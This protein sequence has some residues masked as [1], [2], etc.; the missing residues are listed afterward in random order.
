MGRKIHLQPTGFV[1]FKFPSRIPGMWTPT[2]GRGNLVGM[3]FP[4]R[5]HRR[6]S[7]FYF[8]D[9][10]MIKRERFVSHK[11][12]GHRPPGRFLRFLLGS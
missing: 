1:S 4:P 10:R 9:D 5:G 8:L 6:I 11:L 7:A 2:R 12:I 3:K